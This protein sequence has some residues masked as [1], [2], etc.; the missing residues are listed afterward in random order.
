MKRTLTIGMLVAALIG[1]CNAATAEPSLIPDPGL[2]NGELRYLCGG[3]VFDPAILEQPGTAEQADT[4]KAKVLRA[5]IQQTAREGEAL[6]ET[7]WHLLNDRPDGADYLNTGTPPG[8]DPEVVSATIQLGVAL[9]RMASWNRCQPTV[10]VPKGLNVG[11]WGLDPSGPELGR[12]TQ[13]LRLLVH[14]E[15]CASAQLPTGRVVGPALSFEDDVVV[16]LFGVQQQSGA[17]T[18][19]GNPSLPVTIDLGQQIGDRDLVDPSRWPPTIVKIP[20][21][22]D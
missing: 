9:G 5:Y 6:P 11:S 12:E 17:A 21:A 10:V 15:A 13:V 20:G 7:G 18:C 4:P 22:G 8:S 19:P 14:E 2:L 16:V 3:L 1:A